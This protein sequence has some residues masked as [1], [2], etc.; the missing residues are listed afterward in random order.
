MG[1]KTAVAMALLR[2]PKV[3]FLDEPLEA[4]DPVT[5]KA[6]RDL[7]S[8]IAARGV[9]VFLT[10]HILEMVERLATQIVMIRKAKLVC[11]SATHELT[12]PLEQLSFD[13]VEPPASATLDSL[14]PPP[15]T[16]PLPP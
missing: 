2:N 9:T 5:S 14:P 6:I 12:H 7:L 11:N 1:K 15:A 4:I 13:P 16:R 3:L 8:R 10:S